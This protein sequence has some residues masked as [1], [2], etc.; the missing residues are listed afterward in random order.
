MRTLDPSLAAR[1]RGN[2]ANRTAQKTKKI[3]EKKSNKR[4]KNASTSH[5]ANR[6]TDAHHNEQGLITEEI[7]S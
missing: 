1:L 4:L 7:G 2:R 6:V 5:H 3:P